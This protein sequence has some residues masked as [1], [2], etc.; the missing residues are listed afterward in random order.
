MIPIFIFSGKNKI[1]M[2]SSSP[3]PPSPPPAPKLLPTFAAF[4]PNVSECD[5]CGK[6][7]KECTVIVYPTLN[8][9]YILHCKS[10]RTVADYTR[11]YTLLKNDY[12]PGTLSC[13]PATNFNSVKVQRSSGEIVDAVAMTP[14]WWS[15]EHKAV[16]VLVGFEK[17]EKSV[18]LADLLKVNPEMGNNVTIKWD[19][20]CWWD[21]IPPE[22]DLRAKV[23]EYITTTF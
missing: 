16:M 22:L 11:L 20:S 5:N 14:V 23:E 15:E 17:Y 21:S 12:I 18:R 1:K 7:G 4:I 9:E 10:C 19:S 2:T 3:V 8:R 13:F 6:M